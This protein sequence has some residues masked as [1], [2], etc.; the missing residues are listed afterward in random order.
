MQTA[1][2]V[3]V[4]PATYCAQTHLPVQQ[5]VRRRVAG[6]ARV[7]TDGDEQFTSYEVQVDFYTNFIRFH[8]NWTFVSVY[9][10]E[11][12]SGLGTR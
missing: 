6:Y 12:V 3:T 1:K 10:D 8:P 11:G 2:I 7:S 9:T 5:K 4:I